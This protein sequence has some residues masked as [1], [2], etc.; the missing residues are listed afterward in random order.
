MKWKD[1]VRRYK[2]EWILIDVKKVDKN[3][4]IKE[5]KVLYHSKNQEDIYRKILEL[6]PKSF[7]VEYTGNIP[8]DLAVVLFC[9]IL[10]T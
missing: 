3:F 6:T 5:G 2:D 10:Q 8:D 7:A 1:I 9:E 4:K